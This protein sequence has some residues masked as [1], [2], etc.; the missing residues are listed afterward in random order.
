MYDGDN[1]NNDRICIF[2]TGINKDGGLDNYQISKIITSESAGILFVIDEKELPNLNE[3][4]IDFS[5][6]YPPT[7]LIKK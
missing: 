7:K 3:Y 6:G 5:N 4:K 2:V 1:I